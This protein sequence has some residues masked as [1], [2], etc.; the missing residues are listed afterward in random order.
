MMKNE[1]KHPK[2]ANGRKRPKAINGNTKCAASRQLTRHSLSSRAL[3][4]RCALWRAC[5]SFLQVLGGP[6]R[7]EDGH[8]GAAAGGQGARAGDSPEFVR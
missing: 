6:A 3:K 2:N 4:R 8:S 5:R 7:L 1:N